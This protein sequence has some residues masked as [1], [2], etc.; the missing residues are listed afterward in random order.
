VPDIIPGLAAK[1][2]VP[3]WLVRGMKW[4]E[5]GTN[6]DG[7]F[8][9]SPAGARGPAQLMPGTA[10]RLAK[11]YGINP[12]TYNGNLEGGIAYLGEQLRRFKKPELALAAYNA[13]PGAVAKYGGIPP[14]KETQ[15]YVRS[16]MATAKSGG[17]MAS[18]GAPVAIAAAPATSA[19]L[20]RQQRGQFAMSLIQA[21]RAGDRPGMMAVLDQMRSQLAH[22]TATP[23]N[24]GVSTQVPGAAAGITGDPNGAWGGSYDVARGFAD[25]AQGLGLKSTSEK[26]Q[27]QATSTGG[28]SDHWVGSKNSYAFDLSNGVRT[29]QMDQAASQIAARLGVH[30]NGGPLELTKVVNGYRIQVLYRTQLGGDHNNHIH[31]GVERV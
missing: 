22:P 18:V 27:R 17:G 1:Y 21:R 19:G 13:G 25:L 26:R 30:W 29:K 31:V 12:N 10:A 2:G 16:I 20:T 3:E 4:K 23:Q 6:A 11:T 5:G 28:V 7:S 9:T 14:Y 15:D 8:R 24:A